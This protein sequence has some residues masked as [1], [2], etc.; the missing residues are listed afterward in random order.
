MK[1]NGFRDHNLFHFLSNPV[2]LKKVTISVLFMQEYISILMD[3]MHIR[4]MLTK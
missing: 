2:D 1:T 3:S 4:C